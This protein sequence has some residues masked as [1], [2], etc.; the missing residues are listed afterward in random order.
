MNLGP[1]SPAH[2]ITRHDKQEEGSDE[3]SEV[4][5]RVTEVFQTYELIIT[6]K[7]KAY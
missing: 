6:S 1:I 7:R 2:D 5:Q 3:V 4:K